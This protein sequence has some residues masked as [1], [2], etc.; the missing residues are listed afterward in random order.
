MVAGGLLAVGF[1][2]PIAWAFWVSITPSFDLPGSP[3][4]GSVTFP[5]LLLYSLVLSDGRAITGLANSALIASAT[6]VLTLLLAC[7]A[8]YAIARL[9]L[10]FGNGLLSA[11]L[12]VAFFPPAAVLVPMLVQLRELGVVGTQLGAVVPH[13][14]FFL[15]FAIW[16]LATFFR[17]L[18]VEVE[19]A[20]KVDGAKQLQVLTRVIL[21]LAAPAVFATGA[22]VFVLSW[23]EFVFASTFTF[24]ESRPITVVLA[25]LVAGMS[26]GAPPGPLAAAALLA[27]LPPIILFLTFRRRILSGLTGD[28]LG[29]TTDDARGSRSWTLPKAGVWAAT[30]VLL[31]T[32]V[33][34]LTLFVRYGAGALSF[35]Y[36]STTAKGRCWTRRSGSWTFRTS[37][38]PTCRS[39]RLRSRTTRPCSCSSRRRWCG[40]SVPSTGTDVPSRSPA[41]LPRPS[42][43]RSRSTS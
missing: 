29:E 10:R 13:T 1:L 5:S 17:E 40:C 16:L 34:A 28:A 37:T 7:P 31:L 42:L 19:D 12:A 8:A 26:V 15:P 32:Q 3:A 38:R 6:T 20:A 36:P 27:T 33:W 22:F 2:V 41:P 39:R 30:A 35:P 21:P 9:G 11:M 14:V 43:S 4:E 24:Y 23:N 25:D 18:P